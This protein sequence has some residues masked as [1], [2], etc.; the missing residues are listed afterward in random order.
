MGNVGCCT[1]CNDPKLEL[2]DR[3]EDRNLFS[4]CLSSNA[5][6]PQEETTIGIRK[7]KT[8][9]GKEELLEIDYETALKMED[10]LLY[11]SEGTKSLCSEMVASLDA[12]FIVLAISP[13]YEA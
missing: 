11:I 5:L 1:T 3:K 12:R 10:K 8:I 7:K 4:S 13:D 6:I 2:D 9:N